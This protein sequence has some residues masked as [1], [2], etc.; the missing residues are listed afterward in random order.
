MK[1]NVEKID[2]VSVVT[3]DEEVLDSS[4]HEDFMDSMTPI[5]EKE[6]QI[7]MDIG[8]LEM[9]DSS[10]LG[11]FAYCLRK[12]RDTG[13]KFVICSPSDNVREAFSLV[14]MERI[15][16]IHETRDDALTAL[17]TS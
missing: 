13:G 4:N 10:G 17:A 12:S 3:I 8:N 7:I 11:S 15:I 16:G 6:S 2:G 1:T 9:I 5:L 14:H